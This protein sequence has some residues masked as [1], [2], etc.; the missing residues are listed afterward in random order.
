MDALCSTLRVPFER[1]GIRVCNRKMVTATLRRIKVVE[2]RV[3][4]AYDSDLQITLRQALDV[5]AK[6]S[7][8]DAVCQGAV[9]YGFS[10]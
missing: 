2:A 5:S 9:G 1:A 3:A 7:L 10:T 8:D 4:K 6:T